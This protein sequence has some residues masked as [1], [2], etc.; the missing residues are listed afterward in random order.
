MSRGCQTMGACGE[1]TL[2][3]TLVAQAEAGRN[4]L[5][6][7]SRILRS[8]ADP[9]KSAP[10]HPTRREVRAAPPSDFGPELPM[11]WPTHCAHR[12][13]LAHHALPSGEGGGKSFGQPFRDSLPHWQIRPPSARAPGATS[14]SVAGAVK[15]FVAAPAV[16][17][18]CARGADDPSGCA[19]LKGALAGGARPCETACHRSM[20]GPKHKRWR[21]TGPRSN[22]QHGSWRAALADWPAN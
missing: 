5:A 19:R 20:R 11:P 10:L 8:G 18:K 1:P 7:G 12:W 6:Q 22:R 21:S 3:L 15:A 4:K 14:P 13:G 2:R 17:Q 16:S 9:T